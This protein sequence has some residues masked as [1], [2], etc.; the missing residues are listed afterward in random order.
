[1]LK[2]VADRFR[3]G[4]FAAT[5]LDDIVAATGLKRPSLYAAFGDKKAMYLATLARLNREIAASF[6]RLDDANLPMRETLASLFAYSIAAYLS[7]PDGPRGCLAI[8][9]ASAEAV[10]DPDIRTALDGIITLIDTRIEHSFVRHGVSD[11]APRARLVGAI[12]HSLSIR[13]RAG[14]PR[15][16]LEQMAGDAIEL[17]VPR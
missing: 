2:V 1:M 17:I 12:L 16:V 10:T 6:D 8:G 13:A 11:A 4:G 7:G 15:E 5:S 3:D 14:Q 9:T